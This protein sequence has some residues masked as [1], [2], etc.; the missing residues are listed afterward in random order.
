MADIFLNFALLFF[1]ILLYAGVAIYAERKIAAFIQTRLGPYEV[2]PRGLLQSLADVLKLMQ[3]EEIPAQKEHIWLKRMAPA[4]V[5]VSVV[6]CFALLPVFPALS[7]QQGGPSLLILLGFLSLHVVGV[8][9]AGWSSGSKFSLLGAFRAV[10]QLL[11]YEVPIGLC[12]V[13]VT[14]ATGTL[15]LHTIAAQQ[16]PNFSDTTP[17]FGFL[18]INTA[19]WGGFFTWNVVRSPLLLPVF[20]IFFIG[21]LAQAH[22]TPFDLPEAESELVG[23]YHTEYGGFGW[24]LFMAAEYAIMLILSL[25]SVV[26]FLGGGWSPLP[27]V[28]ALKLADWTNASLWHPF[29]MLAKGTVLIGLNMGIRWTYPRLRTAQLMQFCWKFLVPLCVVLLY[30]IGLWRIFHL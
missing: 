23:G 14:L 7:P 10:A 16:G 18:P 4:V 15:N 22:R 2:G 8:F 1:L 17:L 21:A 27:N 20:L 11:S 9:F 25:V 30:L 24:L 13:C 29:W 3:K 6:S 26:L 12:F 5:F 19:S 28:G